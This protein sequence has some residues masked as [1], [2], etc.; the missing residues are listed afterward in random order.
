[1]AIQFRYLSLP[2]T[3]LYQSTITL[4]TNGLNSPNKKHRMAVNRLEN[5]I[6]QHAFYENTL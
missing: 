2:V 5:K 4:N 6:Q 1:M 3:I